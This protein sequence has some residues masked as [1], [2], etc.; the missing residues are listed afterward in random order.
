MSDDEIWD[1]HAWESFLKENDKRV[2][3]YMNLLFGF[4]TDNPPPDQDDTEAYHAWRAELVAFLES[5][6]WPPSDPHL[7]FLLNEE[8]DE[9]TPPTF[10]FE[11][12]ETD[13]D[14][15]DGLTSF[16]DLAIYQQAFALASFVLDWA[17]ALPTQIK[18]SS[19]VQF[20]AHITQIPANIAKGHSLG[21]ERD[22]LG[23]NIA[24]CRRAID[25]A[26]HALELLPQL[27]NHSALSEAR[28]QQ[29]YE[30][31]YEIRNSIGIYIQDL[32]ARFNLGID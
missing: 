24:C 12:A 30:Q 9:E 31:T 15:L 2:E 3:R 13:D 11:E 22:T 29:L 20:C 28:Y 27:K 5:Q 10:T 18:D 21:Y 14:L 16:R 19:L 1:E 17:H 26:N 8:P 4:M 6:G 32:R 7:S 23:G 25:A